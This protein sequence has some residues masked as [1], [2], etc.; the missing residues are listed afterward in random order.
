[1]FMLSLMLLVVVATV[2]ISTMVISLILTVR[3][4][5]VNKLVDFFLLLLLSSS[6]S[7]S[8]NEGRRD[9]QSR[10]THC[11]LIDDDDECVLL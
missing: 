10:G 8:I 4:D 7:P 2:S 6:S 5:N 9:S 3:F 11:F 1:M